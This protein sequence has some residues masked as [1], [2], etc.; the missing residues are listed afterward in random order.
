M[1]TYAALWILMS[2][3]MPVNAQQEAGVLEEVTV[4]AQ[5]RSTNLID[6]PIAI[7]VL[8]AEDIANSGAWEL[9]QLDQ[10]IPNVLITRNTDFHARI[11]IRGVGAHSRNIG[12]DT[13]VGVYLDGVYVG[14]S[15]S[16]NQDLVDLERIE[17]LRGP[18]GTL[19]G[20][21]AIA[22]A[23]SMVSKKPE[24]DFS[25]K[26][27]VNVFNYD[28]LELKA[29]ANIPLGDK[30]A[31]RIYLSDRQQDGFISNT[32]NPSHVPDTINIV[33]PAAG[34]IFGLPL[35]NTLGGATPAGCVGGPVGPNE[36]PATRNPS[37][38]RTRSCGSTTDCS[39]LPIRQV[40]AT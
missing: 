34:P 29:A 2:V 27:S 11:V 6:V 37:R 17:V 3:C 12:F 26:A 15:P 30:A 36:A 9:S 22:G 16:V 8:S 21:N 5:K 25:A 14:Q 13:R 31:A 4:T 18:Q 28:G 33:H 32:W 35:C 39:S 38:P 23:I 7:T 10:Y 40:P 1:M 24:A 19:F 20:K